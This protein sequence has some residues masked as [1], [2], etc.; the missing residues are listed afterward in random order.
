MFYFLLYKYHLTP[1]GYSTNIQH[2]EELLQ[3]S[4]F[5]SLF[6]HQE[7]PSVGGTVPIR[8]KTN[9]HFSFL[10]AIRKGKSLKISPFSLF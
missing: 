1:K 4:L 5:F 9:S 7:A 10:K 6:P 3:K 2:F 8:K